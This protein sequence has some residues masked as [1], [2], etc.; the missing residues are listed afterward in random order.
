MSFRINALRKL[1]GLGQKCEKQI[2]IHGGYWE[3]P[4]LQNKD[5][6][7]TI[8]CSII[9]VSSIVLLAVAEIGTTI[10]FASLIFT[11]S[12]TS[13]WFWSSKRCWCWCIISDRFW[14]S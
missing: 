13:Y 8:A 4:I 10:F 5:L 1:F 9:Q 2:I 14:S 7:L 12:I 3:R 11:A 6:L